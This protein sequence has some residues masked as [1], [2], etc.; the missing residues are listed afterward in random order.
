[1]DEIL[2][3]DEGWTPDAERLVSDIETLKALSDP[4]RLRI[5]ET[6]V[7]ESGRAWSVK[8]LAGAL[9]VP[10]T[11]LYHHVDLL[12]ERDLVR[13]A[14]RRLVSG[15]VE[16]R[17]RV[18]ALSLRLDRALFR[19][20]TEAGATAL[21]EMLATLFDGA[22]D[23]IERGLAAGRIAAGEDAPPERRLL[24]LR[25]TARLTPDRAE[26]FRARLQ[27]LTEEFGLDDT[28]TTAGHPYGIV[29]AVY[30]TEPP[31]AATSDEERPA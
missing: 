5:L 12:V 19:A 28:K 18:A 22:R 24:L 9:A 1:M 13:A 4:L 11:R 26:E 15:I 29:L 27:A 14:G 21:H 6:M 3:E 30:P 20:D 7:A 8:E 2:V 10:V 31:A 23:D 16:T 17:Y 25:G